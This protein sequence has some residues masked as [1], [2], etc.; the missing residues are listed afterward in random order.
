MAG[1]IFADDPFGLAL[2]DDADDIGPE[3]AGIIGTTAPSGGAEGL[4]AISGEDDVDGTAKGSG[5]E[6]SQIV[7]DR[8]WGGFRTECRLT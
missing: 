7:P 5:I 1:D 2:P 8:G 6:C 3:L 4:A